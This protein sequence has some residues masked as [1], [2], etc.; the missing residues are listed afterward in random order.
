MKRVSAILTMLAA[1]LVQTAA[2]EA[3]TI[4]PLAEKKVTELPNGEFFWR[5]ENLPDVAAAK[6]AAGQGA[7]PSPVRD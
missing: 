7:Y 2:Q 5:I 1:T 6:A 3:L 4:T